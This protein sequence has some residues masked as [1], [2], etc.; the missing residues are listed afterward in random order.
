MIKIYKTF[1]GETRSIEKPEKDCWI[2]LIKPIEPELASISRR[3]GIDPA[4]LRA[5]LD[6]DVY[7]RQ[8][9]KGRGGEHRGYHRRRQEGQ[10]RDYL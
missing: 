4:D 8:P 9:E 6:E 2:N 1:E 10:G 7:K 5:A 3:Y